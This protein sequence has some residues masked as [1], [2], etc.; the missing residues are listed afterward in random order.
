MQVGSFQ[1]SLSAMYV[2]KKWKST[3]LV[4]THFTKHLHTDASKSTITRAL[5]GM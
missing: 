4:F 3:Q 2:A 5:R 1:T